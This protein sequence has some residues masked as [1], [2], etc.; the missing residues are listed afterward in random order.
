MADQRNKVLRGF[1][2]IG[3]LEYWNVG[4]LEHWVKKMFVLI[5]VFR[6]IPLFQYS[7][8]TLQHSQQIAII[9]IGC[10]N[11]ETSC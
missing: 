4:I 1:A 3:I 9:S 5:S 11:S 10:R 2:P 7:G 6:I 8:L